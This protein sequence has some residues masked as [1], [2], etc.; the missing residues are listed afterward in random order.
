VCL[1]VFASARVCA[2]VC[3]CV[4]VRASVCVRVC[5]CIHVCVCVC[6]HDHYSDSIHQSF[7]ISVVRICV[8]ALIG[9]MHVHVG[10][11]IV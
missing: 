1:R 10:V 4:F 5:V 2:C 6:P 7:M 3:V 9:G 11:H 8:S